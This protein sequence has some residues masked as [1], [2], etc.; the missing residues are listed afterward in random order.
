MVYTGTSLG[1]VSF[2]VAV[3]STMCGGDFWEFIWTISKI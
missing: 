1:F 2:I 3:A